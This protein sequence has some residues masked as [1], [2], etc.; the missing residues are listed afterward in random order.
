[1]PFNKDTATMG[2][3][4]VRHHKKEGKPPVGEGI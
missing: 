1:M 2:R 4:I 3:D